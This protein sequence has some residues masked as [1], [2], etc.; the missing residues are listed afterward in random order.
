M[1]DDRA[2]YDAESVIS[3]DSTGLEALHD[4]ADDL[5]RHEI[6]LVVAARMRGRIDQQLQTAGVKR[7]IGPENFYATVRAAVA[8]CAASE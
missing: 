1:T 5:R 6:T 7:E 4:L 8:A 3:I 2:P